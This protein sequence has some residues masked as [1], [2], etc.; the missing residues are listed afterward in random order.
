MQSAKQE[1][2]SEIMESLI[3]TT[4]KTFIIP[5]IHNSKL[6]SVIFK[7]ILSLNFDYGCVVNLKSSVR[8]GDAGRPAEFTRLQAGLADQA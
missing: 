7:Y 1:W 2:K 5:I 8:K 3:K 6:L 4:T